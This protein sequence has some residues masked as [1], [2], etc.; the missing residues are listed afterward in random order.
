VGYGLWSPGVPSAIFPLLRGI[1]ERS[2]AAG[3][4]IAFLE[5]FDA[6]A[7]A[8]EST[9]PWVAGFGGISPPSV[10]MLAPNVATCGDTLGDTPEW[11]P[12]TSMEAFGTTTGGAGSVVGYLSTAASGDPSTAHSGAASLSV[13]CGGGDKMGAKTTFT[14]LTPGLDYTF[15]YYAYNWGGFGAQATPQVFCPG[16]LVNL[17]YTTGGTAVSAFGWSRFTGTFNM[18]SPYN[19][20]E[21]RI[22]EV[23]DNAYAWLVDDVQ[24]EQAFSASS[25][26]D[27]TPIVVPGG[28]GFGALI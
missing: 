28:G 20:V 1:F 21:L 2:L 23:L 14:G 4:G 16:G 27:P 11:I 26:Q 10:N 24:L 7:F 22:V 13:H 19:V 12:C 6:P 5:A 25:W 3:V 8:M 17:T 15:S 18:P 9:Q